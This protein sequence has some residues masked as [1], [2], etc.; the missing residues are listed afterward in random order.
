M[1]VKEWI[2]L[3]VRELKQLKEVHKIQEGNKSRRE[4]WDRENI[5]VE[6]I[7]W[8]QGWRY[9]STHSIHYDVSLFTKDRYHEGKL[10][11]LL[12]VTVQVELIYSNTQFRNKFLLMIFLKKVLESVVKY[13][14]T[15]SFKVT[16]SV[17]LF[18]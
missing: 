5:V 18:L 3:D 4:E 7:K 16:S 2:Y 13:M 1:N 17:G 6:I 10:F 8:N 9:S 12:R 15:N 11:L 14:L